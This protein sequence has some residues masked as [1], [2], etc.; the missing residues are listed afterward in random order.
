MNSFSG[1]LRKTIL[2]RP[3]ENLNYSHTLAAFLSITCTLLDNIYAY[4]IITT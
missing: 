4:I 2:I 1:N 3:H